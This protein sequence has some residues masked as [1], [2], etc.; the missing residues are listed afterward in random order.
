M[1]DFCFA[2][3]W[4]LYRA[5][6]DTIDVATKETVSSLFLAEAGFADDGQVTRQDFLELFAPA[7]RANMPEAP[8][9]VE[10]QG[11]AGVSELEIAVHSPAEGLTLDV[12][13][14]AEEGA[15]AALRRE[16][17]LHWPKHAPLLLYLGGR[18]LEDS[19]AISELRG[20]LRGGAVVQALP[21]QPGAASSCAVS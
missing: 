13:L 5:L 4:T 1:P 17:A 11:A 21:E 16:V 20:R 2:L 3:T 9:E 15:V 6:G 14:R 12:E 10:G 18:L 19:T 8:A 7:L